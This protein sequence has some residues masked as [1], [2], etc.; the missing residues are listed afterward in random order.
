MNVLIFAPPPPLHFPK[1]DPEL[2]HLW[3][4]YEGVEYTGSPATDARTINQFL[5]AIKS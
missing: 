2:D 1:W 4:E 5:A 3:H